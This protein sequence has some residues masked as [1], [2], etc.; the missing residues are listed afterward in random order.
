M[1]FDTGWGCGGVSLGVATL[2]LVTVNPKVGD[3]GRKSSAPSAVAAIKVLLLKLTPPC[4]T[5][6][7]S[8]LC[9]HPL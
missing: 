1:N 9:R 7:I 4:L 2:T 5:E 3:S 6:S 8:D